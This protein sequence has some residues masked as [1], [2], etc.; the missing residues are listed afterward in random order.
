M[1]E[2][3]RAS[4]EE[5]GKYEVEEILDK[6]GIQVEWSRTMRSGPGAGG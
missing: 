5:N 6:R 1:D 2:D 3:V 4:E